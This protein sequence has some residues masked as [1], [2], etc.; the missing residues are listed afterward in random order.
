VSWVIPDGYWSDH[1]GTNKADGGPGWV[2]AIVNAV[3]GVDNDGVVH[4]TCYDTINGQQYSY[5]QDTVILITWDDWGGFYDDVDPDPNGTGYVNSGNNNGI[6]YVYGFRVPLLVVSAYAKQGYTSNVPHDFGS[7]L[8]FIE[9]T[10]NITTEI[11]PPY[12][13]ADFFAPDGPNP[14]ADFFNYTQQQRQFSVIQGANYPT[15]CYVEPHSTQEHFPCFPNYP[16]DPDND[17]IDAQD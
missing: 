11:N 3:G 8:S 12:H 10:F 15:M 4:P 9:H 13:Y 6:Q 17:A 7:I 14:L 1:A 2:A 5:W 16:S